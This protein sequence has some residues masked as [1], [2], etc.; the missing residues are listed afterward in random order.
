MMD[1][2]SSFDSS[3]DTKKYS[4]LQNPGRNSGKIQEEIEG[5]A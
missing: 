2:N 4:E 1:F 5:L 3:S